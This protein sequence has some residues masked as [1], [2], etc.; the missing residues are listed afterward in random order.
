MESED[1]GKAHRALTSSA[2]VLGVGAGEDGVDGCGFERAFPSETAWPSF[3]AGRCVFAVSRTSRVPPLL[4]RAFI[5]EGEL[6]LAWSS[7]DFAFLH[8]EI[9]YAQC[10]VDS[11]HERPPCPADFRGIRA[12]DY[13]LSRYAFS[14]LPSGAPLRGCRLLHSGRSSLIA[15]AAGRV[16]PS[17]RYSRGSLAAPLK[18]K[19]LQNFLATSIDLV[20]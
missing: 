20:W 9:P 13:R 3:T 1:V 15:P 19:G 6:W 18:S 14:G 4:L 8:L 2:G 10:R 17:G 11:E 5:A 7:A 16:S 12:W